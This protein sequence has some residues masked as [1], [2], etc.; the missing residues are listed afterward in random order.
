ME[1]SFRLLPLQLPSL[2]QPSPEEPEMSLSHNIVLLK[3]LLLWSNLY[4]GGERTDHLYSMI[5]WLCVVYLDSINNNL[6]KMR[7]K[8]NINRLSH[9]DALNITLFTVLPLHCKMIL[10]QLSKIILMIRLFRC[11]LLLSDQTN[12]PSF[13]SYCKSPS[14]QSGN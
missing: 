5:C 10:I 13:G 9:V 6:T 3:S 2:T 14:R 1:F 12:K 7:Q 8:S 11:W 4:A